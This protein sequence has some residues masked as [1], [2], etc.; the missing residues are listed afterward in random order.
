MQI[1][2]RK[3]RKGAVPNPPQN[4]SA[5]AVIENVLLQDPAGMY[6]ARLRAAKGEFEKVLPA[7]REFLLQLVLGP[8]KPTTAQSDPFFLP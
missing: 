5:I 1:V 2:I 7:F 8:S 4:D 3:A 6:T